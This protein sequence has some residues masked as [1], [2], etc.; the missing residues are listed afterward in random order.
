MGTV[1]GMNNE[2]LKFYLIGDKEEWNSGELFGSHIFTE[3]ILSL[4][5]S[6]RNYTE[7]GMFPILILQIRDRNYFINPLTI[8]K[9]EKLKNYMKAIFK[10][11]L[12]RTCHS[13]S[14]NAMVVGIRNNS[15]I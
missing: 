7:K 12:S 5:N 6:V 10:I 13:S 1:W 2:K 8:Q 3:I 11:L 14:V 4:A 9:T 15:G